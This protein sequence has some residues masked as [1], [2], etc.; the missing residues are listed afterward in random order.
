MFYRLIVFLSLLFFVLTYPVAIFAQQGVQTSPPI[1][2]ER[3]EGKITRILEEKEITIEGIG[4]KQEYQKLEVLV[5]RGSK[6][7]RTITIEHGTIPVVNAIRYKVGDTIVITASK[8]FEGKE[9]YYITDYVRRTP[10]YILFAIFVV[11]TILIGRKR[12]IA[13]LV[14]MALSFFII[15]TF[16]LPQISKGSDP[17]LVAIAAS[18]IIIPVTFYFSHGVNR[19]THAAVIGTFIALMI[20]GILAIVFVDAARLTGFASEEAGFLE[21]MKQGT[22]NIRGLLLAGII[23]GVLG[24]LD[25]IT[26][27]QAAIV[28]QLKET[29]PLLSIGQLYSKGM[30]IGRDHIASM[31]N[32]LI[33]VYTGAAMPL[34]LLFI[35]NSISFN[36]VINYE[37]LAEEII[38]TLVASI[39]LILAVPITTLIAAWIINVNNSNQN[40]PSNQRLFK[41]KKN[42]V[43]KRNTSV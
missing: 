15:F 30:N 5:T 10:L 23:I 16:I 34:L 24:I 13:S 40:K 32:T 19:K 35:N 31:V 9:I 33:L 14:G 36:E 11:L 22:I 26:I 39:G 17:I 20:T 8:D 2:E 27:S 38:R 42:R 28:Q 29:N 21:T 37:L 25:D 7:D 12:G 4:Q 1:E 18:F 6:K 3:L 41:S 43:T